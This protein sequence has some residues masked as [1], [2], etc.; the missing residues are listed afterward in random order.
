MAQ[1]HIVEL[2][3]E[4]HALLLEALE[5]HCNALEELEDTLYNLSSS[6]SRERYRQEHNCRELTRK[7]KE[8]PVKL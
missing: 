2:T 3:S 6:L 5:T 8:A 7:L 4:E 1:T